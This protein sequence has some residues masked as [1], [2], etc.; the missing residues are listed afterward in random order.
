MVSPVKMFPVQILEITLSLHA[1]EE[2]GAGLRGADGKLEPP[3]QVAIKKLMNEV[4]GF[5]V[6]I[7]GGAFASKG[8]S[9]IE[10]QAD[11]GAMFHELFELGHIKFSLQFHSACGML[12]S[13]FNSE[14]NHVIAG[15]FHVI[16]NFFV[17]G[18]LTAHDIVFQVI[19]SIFADRFSQFQNIFFASVMNLFIEKDSLQLRVFCAQGL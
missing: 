10:L 16:E 15:T 14:P 9:S 17:H 13:S 12:A 8:K 2:R 3:Q 6:A 19:E 11:A 18:P 7:I 5:F 4:Q 1:I